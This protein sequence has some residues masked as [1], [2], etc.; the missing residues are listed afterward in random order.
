MSSA[1]GALGLLGVGTSN[2]AI[3]LPITCEGNLEGLEVGRGGGLN[4]ILG[5][6]IN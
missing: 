5:E 3:C 4:L 2:P 1:L 6:G